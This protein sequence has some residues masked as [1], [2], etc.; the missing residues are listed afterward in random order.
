[1]TLTRRSTLFGRER[2][3]S[4]PQYYA[5]LTQRLI[6]ALS[7]SPREGLLYDVDFRLRPSGN[8]GPIAVRLKAFEDY[9]AKE[10]WTWERM[11]LTRARVVAGD[12]ELAFRTEAAIR[13]ALTSPREP[14][15][16]R[17]DVIDM[18]RLLEKEKGSKNPFSLKQVS[19]GQIDIEFLTQYLLLRHAPACPQCLSP[20]IVEALLHLRDECL[21]D[22]SAAGTLIEAAKLYQG[23]T[24]FPP[25]DA[26]LRGGIRTRAPPC[27]VSAH[28]ATGDP[29]PSW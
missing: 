14:A 22:G 21:L 20:S 9:Q 23:L 25:H 5:R 12:A 4:A 6:A 2:S 26:R 7:A 29:C 19:G 10:A 1:M 17:A 8:K 3:L 27:T 11:A 18:R 15:K 13:A 24:R 28:G 16:L